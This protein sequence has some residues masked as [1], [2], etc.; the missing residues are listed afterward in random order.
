MPRP[1]KTT[2][3]VATTE[4]DTTLNPDRAQVAAVAD[5]PHAPRIVVDSIP[6]SA[7][8][9]VARVEQMPEGEVYAVHLT[10]LEA[11]ALAIALY[12]VAEGCSFPEAMQESHDLVPY[13]ERGYAKLKGVPAQ[14]PTSVPATPEAMDGLRATIAEQ[15]A[16]IASLTA[17]GQRCEEEISKKG[18]RIAELEAKADPAGWRESRAYRD[19]LALDD[20]R[21]AILDTGHPLGDDS[22]PELTPLRLVREV[23]AKVP[24]TAHD[25]AAGYLAIVSGNVR[26]ARWKR[27]ILHDIRDPDMV[28]GQID[29]LTDGWAPSVKG[30]AAPPM[31]TEAEAR[32]WCEA[33]CGWTVV[34]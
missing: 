27:N 30:A 14:A 23:L 34:A 7:T 10:A 32:A 3:T 9:T 5:L 15:S 8:V 26:A 20:I 24:R 21:C 28:I 13:A 33:R 4:P 2:P 1:K 6:E 11:E 18:D 25:H 19:S 29:H 17:W 16:R 12:D 31:K 22:D